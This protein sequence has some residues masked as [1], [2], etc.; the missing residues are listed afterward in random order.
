MK[1]STPCKK[2]SDEELMVLIRNEDNIYLRELYHR[3]NRRL[4]YF[5]YRM[6]GGDEAKALFAGS[7]F[8]NNREFR[9]L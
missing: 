9:S 5:F 8:K 3:Y 4:L 1:W 7:I 6:F 2:Y